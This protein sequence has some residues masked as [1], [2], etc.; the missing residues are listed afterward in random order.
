MGLGRR[1]PFLTSFALILIL[2]APLTY[3]NDTIPVEGF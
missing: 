2:K 1:F 3:V